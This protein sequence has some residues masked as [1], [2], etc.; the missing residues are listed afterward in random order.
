MIAL[1]NLEATGGCDSALFLLVE[2][3]ATFEL[4]GEMGFLTLLTTALAILLLLILLTM[5]PSKN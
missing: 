3:L 1:A 2:P 4:A 5:G